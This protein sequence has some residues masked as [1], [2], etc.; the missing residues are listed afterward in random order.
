MP[1]HTESPTANVMDGLSRFL[2]CWRTKIKKLVEKQRK[3]IET[4]VETDLESIDFFSQSSDS[5]TIRL[6]TSF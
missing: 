1:L 5:N 3:D 4:T 6:G 2:H